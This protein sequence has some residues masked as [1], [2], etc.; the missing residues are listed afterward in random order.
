MQKLLRDWLHNCVFVCVCHYLYF[1][2]EMNS[3]QTVFVTVMEKHF[4]QP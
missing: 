3:K 1:K 2:M 4:E